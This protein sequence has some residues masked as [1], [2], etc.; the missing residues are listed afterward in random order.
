MGWAH[1]DIA[2]AE[3]CA[4][5]PSRNRALL[6]AP[7]GWR[8]LCGELE[9]YERGFGTAGVGGGV[10]D[11]SEERLGMLLCC[12]VMCGMVLIRPK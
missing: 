8:E 9:D 2:Q 6:W 12:Q 7:C 10:C 11:E 1:R 4:R 3:A 5:R